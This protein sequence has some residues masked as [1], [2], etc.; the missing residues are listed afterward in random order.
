MDI[1]ATPRSQLT[2]GI[3]GAGGVTSGSHLPILANMPA[4]RVAWLCDP[5]VDRARDLA[6][7]YA[8]AATYPHIDQCPDVDLVLVAIPV[9]LRDRVMPTVFARSWHA[10][11]EKPYAITLA[12]HDE[13]LAAADER[14]VETGVAF[15]RRFAAPTV[16]AR[17]LLAAA[18]FG[19]ILRVSACEGFAVRGTGKSG[20]YLENPAIGGG[21]VLMET[22]SHLIDQVLTILQAT[23]ASLIS[24]RQHRYAGVDLASTVEAEV[25]SERFGPVPCHFEVSM[26]S[27]LCNGIFVEFADHVLKVDLSFEGG[28]ELLSKGGDRVCSYDTPDG[29]DTPAKGY[30]LEWREFLDQCRT[31]R[32]SMVSASTARHTTALI[33]RSYRRAEAAA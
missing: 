19:P 13:Y 4:A 26:L 3:V 24:C 33:E 22:G 29:A 11:C 25:S 9:G 8:I 27:D 7:H 20:W 32:R 21:G 2:V 18:P 10:F 16:L 23:D 14:D 12:E 6:T 17:R 5:A 31:R 1:E 28:V 15:V 30:Y